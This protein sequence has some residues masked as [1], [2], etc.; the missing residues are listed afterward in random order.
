MRTL[1]KPQQNRYISYQR[2]NRE[3]RDCYYSAGDIAIFKQYD[4]RLNMLKTSNPFE[5]QSNMK[6]YFAG[7]YIYDIN[8][9]LVFLLLNY[10]QEQ[11]SLTEVINSMNV[12][13]HHKER[14]ESYCLGLQIRYRYEVITA[15]FTN[16]MEVVNILI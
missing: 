5:F 10:K 3:E 2:D 11:T 12:S 13:I 7:N 8:T 1:T 9:F 4:K 16:D 6:E 14:L 15:S